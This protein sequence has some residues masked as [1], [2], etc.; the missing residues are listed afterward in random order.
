[1]LI[2]YYPVPQ[3]STQNDKNT[4]SQA[5]DRVIATAS[6]A[7]LNKMIEA[8]HP[9]DSGRKPVKTIARLKDHNYAVNVMVVNL[10]YDQPNLIPH[11]GFG[12]LIPQNVPLEQNPERALGVIFGS[13]TSQGQDTAPGTKLT[14]M[15]GGHWWD[16]W[17][18][19]DIPSTEEAIAMSRRLLKRH[20]GIDETPAVARARFQRQ[21]VPQYTVHHLHR[22]T[23]LSGEVREEF[24]SRLT[25]AGNWYGITGVGLTNCVA[26]AY[27][28]A[29]YGVGSFPG[30]PKEPVERKFVTEMEKQV[31]GVAY[32]PHLFRRLPNGINSPDEF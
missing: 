1:L 9:E 4:E 28:A 13:E 30:P 7:E 17:P 8:G 10:Y 19:S 26:Q 3:I 20:I 22:M 24:N 5:F 2:L 32:H 31:G 14:I 21:A 29:S 18:D 23:T 6:P 11:R 15:M 12:Y 27:L 16:N 25:L